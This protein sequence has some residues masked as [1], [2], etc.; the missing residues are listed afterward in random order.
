MVYNRKYYPK[1][2]ETESQE[3]WLHPELVKYAVEARIFNTGKII[4]KVRP[5]LE[6]EKNNM[7]ETR[8]CDV[9]VD[10]FDSA[11]EADEFCRQYQKT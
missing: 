6:G 9:W 7:H 5:A 8:A 10:V 4:V 11:Q 3:N 1:S 2:G